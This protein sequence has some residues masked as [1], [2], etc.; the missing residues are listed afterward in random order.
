[1]AELADCGNA[2]KGAPAI[3]ATNVG[4]G[5]VEDAAMTFDAVSSAAPRAGTAPTGLLPMR[6]RKHRIEAAPRQ[7]RPELKHRTENK[8]GAKFGI[9]ETIFLNPF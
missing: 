4:E 1:L 9:I 6:P 8:A 2:G 7:Y 3:G 5:A